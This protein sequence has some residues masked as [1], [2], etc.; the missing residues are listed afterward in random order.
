ML[1]LH[2]ASNGREFLLVHGEPQHNG[3]GFLID[4]A[5]KRIL[6]PSRKDAKFSFADTIG[7]PSDSILHQRCSKIEDIAQSI[8]LESQVS[9]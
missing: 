1:T 9:V 4:S 5:E 3:C 6:T 8:A 2:A 7:Y